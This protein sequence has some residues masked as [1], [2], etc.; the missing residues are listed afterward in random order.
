MRT[1]IVC[2]IALS[3]LVGFGAVYA[4]DSTSATQEK[5]M[6]MKPAGVKELNAFHVLLHPLV[7]DA[8]P[9]KDYATVKDALPKLIESAQTLLKAQLPKTIGPKKKT[10]RTE[11][12]KLLTQLTQ[13][14]RKKAELSDEQ[15]EKNFAAMHETFEELMQM[16]E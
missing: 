9:N 7:H 10:F 8:M 16:T 6:E 3:I 1:I 15:F 2:L 11:T 13:L 4:Q 5:K 12:K 14:N